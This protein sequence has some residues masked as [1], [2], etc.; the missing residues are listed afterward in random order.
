VPQEIDARFFV[1]A[2]GNNYHD[3]GEEWLD[4]LQI[5]WTDPIG[6][7]NF[8]TS[9]L[10]EAI[11]VNHEAHVEAVE[12]GTHKISIWDQPGC[13]VGWITVNGVRRPEPGSQDVFVQVPK[14]NKRLSIFV[15]VQC[16]Q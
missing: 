9:Y 13:T 2:N 3:V 14:T 10:D 12:E 4:G 8:K 11:D 1:D 15:D 16:V 6:G 7:S 5:K